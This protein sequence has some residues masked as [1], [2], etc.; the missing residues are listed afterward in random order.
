M[1]DRIMILPF[2]VILIVVLLLPMSATEPCDMKADV[3]EYKFIVAYQLTMVKGKQL[4]KAVNSKLY[5]VETVNIST[6]TPVPEDEV[7]TMD[8][9][10]ESRLVIAV[11]GTIPGPAIEAYIGQT[12]IVYV[13]NQ[14]YSSDVTIHWHGLHQRGTPFM[15]GVPYVTQCPIGPSQSFAYKFKLTQTGT[16]WYHSHIGTQRTMGLYGAFIIREKNPMPI[17]EHIMVV[18]DYNHHWDSDVAY[19]RTLQGMYVKQKK[20]EN[21][22]SLDG[23]FFSLFNFHSGLV[24]GRGRFYSQKGIHN[25]APLAKFT[26][27]PG[28]NYRFRVISASAQYP[29]EI[30]V[31]G[32]ELQIV[33]SDGSGLEPYIADVFV[34]NPGE[35]FDFIITTNETVGNYWIR[36]KT[37]EIEKNNRFEAILHYEGAPDEEPNSSPRNCTQDDPCNVLNCAFSFY[38][39]DQHRKCIPFSELNSTSDYEVPRVVRGK[40]KE[41]FLNFAFPGVP[42]KTPGSVN[43]RK[44]VEPSVN[45]LYQPDEVDTLCDKK[46]CGVD[47]IC[48]C[49]Y[50]LK[51]IK[52]DTIQ[53]IFL[54]MGMGKGSHH[55]IHM[56]GYTFS[57]V[58]MGYPTFNETT[59]SF[60]A[61]TSD[62]DCR[63]DPKKNFCNDAAWSN[64]NW[65][66]DNI[67]GIKLK[68]APLKDT[69]IVP[70]G[71][72][73]VIR[74]KADNPGLW[75][76][77]CHIEMHNMDGMAM[78]LNESFADVP[79]APDYFPVCR[80]FTPEAISRIPVVT[81]LE[82]TTITT[83]LINLEEDIQKDREI[84]KMTFGILVAVICVLCL[85]IIVLTVVLSKRSLQ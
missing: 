80:N 68:R 19:V 30:S 71:G 55:P 79:K 57:V 60:I 22:H 20:I 47:R 15:D 62:V 74:I 8:G 34:I 1:V 36:G 18:T 46:D 32:H 4:L 58:K 84:E 42:G 72:Y 49:T 28:N 70:S 44:Y 76:M 69:I 7:I 9:Y 29:F 77:H 50:S 82:T 11:N 40:W 85:I 35:R 45:A 48:G 54:N 73:A 17:L 51:L 12:V 33:A 43:G 66:G 25:E 67:P 21:T 75:F 24:N 5:P 10:S 81:V 78:L 3:C 63:G 56:H 16:Y 64:S 53:M 6:A 37:T 23:S 61:D 27:K 31:D 59:G 38:P 2:G 41:Y 39:M 14:L 65:G 13:E 52:G 83:P 26:V